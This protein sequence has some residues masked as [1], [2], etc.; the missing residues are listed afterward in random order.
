L[1]PEGERDPEFDGAIVPETH[2][3]IDPL[4]LNI[5]GN[6]PVVEREDLPCPLAFLAVESK[7]EVS[8]GTLYASG[9]VDFS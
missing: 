4:A 1:E 6:E 3:E 2:D 7:S 8:N 5:V 9:L